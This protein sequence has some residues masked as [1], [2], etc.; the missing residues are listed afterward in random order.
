[1]CVSYTD[2]D[3]A[4]VFALRGLDL[5]AVEL[6]DGDMRDLEHNLATGKPPTGRPA[7]DLLIHADADTG[8]LTA[9]V[10]ATFLYTTREGTHGLIKT[11]D[12]VVRTADLTGRAG[13]AP[14]GV[15]FRRGVRFNWKPLTGK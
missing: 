10:N 9:N 2:P 13:D 1:M 14:A 15:G 4:E 7:G 6:M 5:K 12:R 8:D 11:T 3:G